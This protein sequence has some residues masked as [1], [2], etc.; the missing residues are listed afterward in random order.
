M[1]TYEISEE[2]ASVDHVAL[3]ADGLTLAAGTSS[4]DIHLL[5]EQGALRWTFDGAADAPDGVTQR[6]VTG[7][8]MDLDGNRILAGFTDD[9]GTE[10]AAGV[11]YLLDDQPIKLWSVTIGGPVSDVS[12]SDNGSRI[13]AGS[14][15]SNLY[16]LTDEGTTRWIYETPVDAGQP[17]NGAAVSPDGSRSVAGSQASQV[18]LLNTDGA[19]IWTVDTDGP[20]NDVAIA[21]E[22]SRVAAGTASGSVYLFNSQGA[23]IRQVSNPETSILAVALN[24]DGTRLAAGSADGRVFYFDSQGIMLWE[25]FLGGSIT[26]VSAGSTTSRVAASSGAKVYMLSGQIP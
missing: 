10:T 20:V 5:N 17:V 7:L 12:I 16:S 18:Y 2:G 1:W 9:E 14:A 15:D 21:S 13:G 8:A 22:G 23:A 24:S 25:V 19:K 4:G 11:L 6:R 3:R 26:S